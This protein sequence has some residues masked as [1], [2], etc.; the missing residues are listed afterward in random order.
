ML[1]DEPVLRTSA[2]Q[3]NIVPGFATDDLA[4]VGL[5]LPPD[6]D[7][8]SAG[9]FLA[10]LAPLVTSGSDILGHRAVARRR[11]RP[12]SLGSAETWLNVG[13]SHA[14][15]RR[16]GLSEFSDPSFREGLSEAAARRLGDPPPR[17]AEVGAGTTGPIDVLFLV[18]AAGP[19]ATSR[20]AATLGADAV[21]HGFVSTVEQHGRRLR[22]GIEH[23]GF[24]DGV[25]QPGLLGRSEEDPEVPLTARPWAEAPD[26]TGALFV[27]A[28]TPLL[29]PGEFL[30]GYPGQ[31]G[32]DRDPGPPPTAFRAPSPSHEAW[33]RDGAYLVFRQMRQD[34]AGFWTYCH[35]QADALAHGPLPGATPEMVGA[36]IVGRWRDGSPIRLDDPDGGSSRPT[37]NDFDLSDDPFG[38]GCPLGAH[39]RKVNPRSGAIADTSPL[40]KRLLRRGIPYGEAL[41][42]IVRRGDPERGL[43]FLAYMTSITDQFEFLV[44]RWVNDP[45][46]PSG[47]GSGQDV[48]IGQ[49]AADRTMTVRLPGGET[50]PFVPP[51]A[52]VE[53]TAG[54]YL[55]APSIPAL[56][57]LGA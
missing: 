41:P 13:L 47:S 14:L 45:H 7:A 18:A 17:A 48:L 12:A 1:P 43:L 53:T 16:L 29:W 6:A 23:F 38:F 28:G 24:V 4:L 50:W 56:A 35:D 33:A 42:G 2:I 34:V 10:S 54:Q 49:P 39:T 9:R 37:R 19:D 5:T 44:S 31:R 55:F 11:R 8:T 25:S 32:T 52:F 46:A 57:E 27:D 26:G 40:D 3:G 36:L 51:V 20:A 21:A 15:L 22:R 30:F